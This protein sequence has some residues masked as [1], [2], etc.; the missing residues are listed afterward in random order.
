MVRFIAFP[1]IYCCRIAPI[2]ISIDC[3]GG[4]N[5]QLLL[6]I[7]GTHTLVD[8]LRS[9]QDILAQYASCGFYYDIVLLKM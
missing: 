9:Q 6:V 3:I 8:I 5:R 7:T 1:Q 4:E 2:D